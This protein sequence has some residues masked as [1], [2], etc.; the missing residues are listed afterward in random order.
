[1]RVL[2]SVVRVSIFRVKVV[3][4]RN[5]VMVWVRVLAFNLLGLGLWAGTSDFRRSLVCIDNWYNRALQ[6]QLS[7]TKER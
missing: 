3:V 4:V 1:M 7:G 6:R 2:V 5:R